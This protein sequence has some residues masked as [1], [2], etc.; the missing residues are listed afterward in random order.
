MPRFLVPEL[1]PGSE[2]ELPPGEARHAVRSRRL[3]E[4]DKVT[5]FDGRGKSCRAEIVKVDGDRVAVRLGPTDIDSADRTIV[6]AAALPKGKRLAWMIQKLAELGVSEFL[7]VAFRRSVVRWSPSR[8]ARLEKIAIEAA[9][10]SDR[11]DLMTLGAEVT[12]EELAGFSGRTFVADPTANQTLAEA[13]GAGAFARV[14]IGPE[15]GFAPGEIETL[16]A[17][18]VL[19]GRT[20]LRIETAAIA[21]AAILGQV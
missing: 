2:V 13:A 4:G 7:P 3:R 6:I 1:A 8:A 11:S 9:K 10:Q 5:L 19:L 18:P 17:T 16:K 14:V 15:G 12:P 21:A 20:V